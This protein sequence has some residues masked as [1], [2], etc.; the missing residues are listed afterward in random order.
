MGLS[1]NLS[2]NQKDPLEK[3][4]ERSDYFWRIAR[5][6]YWKQSE[7]T[8]YVLREKDS[9]ELSLLNQLFNIF[10]VGKEIIRLL[11]I[12]NANL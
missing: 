7:S 11:I 3:S 2:V 4:G 10:Q 5:S 12:I 6:W 8:L 1:F 9:I